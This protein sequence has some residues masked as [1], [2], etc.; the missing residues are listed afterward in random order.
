MSITERGAAPADVEGGGGLLVTVDGN[1]G[2]SRSW[3]PL[4]YQHAARRLG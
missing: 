2:S 1:R 4:W 3:N